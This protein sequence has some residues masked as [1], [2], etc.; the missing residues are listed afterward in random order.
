[1]NRIGLGFDSHRFES[2]K[3]LMLAGVHVDYDRGLA[4]HSDGDAALHALID[5]ML[6]AAS[7]GDIGEMFPDTDPKWAGADSGKLTTEA[8]GQLAVMGWELVN[9]DIVI[10]TESPKL[11]PYKEAM[12]ERVADLLGVDAVSVGL[13][14][15]TAE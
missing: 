13:K 3:P 6:G 14:A 12:R 15:K 1:M 10:V 4:G 5:A 8:V 7:L 11:G 2:G 9:C